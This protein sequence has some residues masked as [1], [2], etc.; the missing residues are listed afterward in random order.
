MQ[1]RARKENR[2]YGA[3]WSPSLL[4]TVTATFGSLSLQRRID[5]AAQARLE[6]AHQHFKRAWEGCCSWSCLVAIL[7]RLPSRSLRGVCEREG[8]RAA[9]LANSPVQHGDAAPQ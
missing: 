8:R 9:S 1:L 5:G 4:G 7:L 2:K 3:G 6:L